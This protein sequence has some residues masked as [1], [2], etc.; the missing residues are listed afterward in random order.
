MKT[1]P[2]VTGALLAFIT[3]TDAY[4]KIPIVKNRK[5]EAEQ[6][7]QLSKRSRQKVVSEELGNARTQGLYYAN[8]TIGSPPQQLSLQ[9]DTGSSDVWVPASGSRYCQSVRGCPGGS[10][11]HFSCLHIHPES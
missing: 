6:L 10:C 11:K 8:I 4:I 2:A 1:P 7:S 3:L 5:V 9:I